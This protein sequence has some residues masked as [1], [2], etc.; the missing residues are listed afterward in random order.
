MAEKKSANKERV[1]RQTLTKRLVAKRSESRRHSRRFDDLLKK[2][3]AAPL[4]LEEAMVKTKE[5]ATTKFDSSIE[6]HVRLK[7]KKAKKGSDDELTR[8]LVSLPHGLGKV[9]RVAVL[10][11]EIIAA[12][13]KSG[14]IDFDIA[15]ASPELMPKLGKVAR[16]LGTKGKM[17]NPKAGTVTTTL[18]E[19]KARIEAGQVEWRQDAGRAIHQMIGKASWDAERLS[20]NARAFLRAF[21]TTR[22]ESV[23]LTSTMGPAVATALD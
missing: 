11:E 19:T 23:Y 14:T 20:E 5:L 21:P 10:T 16:L 12:L 4:A 18:D 7:A 8:G 3:P 13:E 6:I 17:P 1:S 9:R 22:I 2:I 15:I